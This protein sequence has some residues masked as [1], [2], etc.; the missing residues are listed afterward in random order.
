MSELFLFPNFVKHVDDT[1]Y[2]LLPGQ[3]AQI[4]MA[5]GLRDDEVI[6]MGAGKNPMESSVLLL[7]FPDNKNN[8]RIVF[9]QRPPYDGVHGGQISLPGGRREPLDENPEATALREAEEEVGIVSADVHIKGHLSDLYIPP[10]NHLVS[11]YIGIIHYYPSFI[12]D[13]KEVE[14]ILELPVNGF[15][16]KQNVR[17]EEIIH[18]NGNRLPAPCYF[19]D[20]HIIWGATAMIMAEF[21][22]LMAG[23]GIQS[24]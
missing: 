18:A 4:V 6:D 3:E 21:V 9:I 15:F 16:Q 7:L 2:S 22:T 5:P 20:G 11:P 23:Q 12:P 17:E 10:S 24:A 1:D 8:T 14:Q 19:V 13:N